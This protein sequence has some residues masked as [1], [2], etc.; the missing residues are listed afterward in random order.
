MLKIKCKRCDYQWEYKGKSEWYTSCP[1]CKTTV[2]IKKL[3][4]KESKLAPYIK[5]REGT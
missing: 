2:N 3:K 1:K 5:G 4:G